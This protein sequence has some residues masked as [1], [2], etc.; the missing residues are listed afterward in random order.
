MLGQVCFSTKRK[1]IECG[2]EREG[3]SVGSRDG[4]ESDRSRGPK[5]PE[6][7]LKME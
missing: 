1:M 2:L 6:K 4:D 5:D 7:C 3:C